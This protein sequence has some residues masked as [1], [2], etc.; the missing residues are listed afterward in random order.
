MYIRHLTLRG[1]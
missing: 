1:L